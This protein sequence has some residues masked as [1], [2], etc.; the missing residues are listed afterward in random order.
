MSLWNNLQR[1]V[2]FDVTVSASGVRRL[3]EGGAFNFFVPDA[4]LIRVNTVI[5]LKPFRSKTN[6]INIYMVNLFSFLKR[7][8]SFLLKRN[9]FNMLLLF[10][11]RLNSPWFTCTMTTILSQ[12]K[13]GPWKRDVGRK[14]QL[15]VT[16]KN[17]EQN[18]LP[19]HQSR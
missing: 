13:A 9:F 14:R 12:R 8:N 4:A 10:L 3:F 11:R 15:F 1:S 17:S 7:T 2:N 18:F 5:V 6:R 19:L 16:G